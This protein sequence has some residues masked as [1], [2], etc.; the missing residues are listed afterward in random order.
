MYMLLRTGIG[1]CTCGKSAEGDTASIKRM[2]EEFDG[3]SREHLAINK[4]TYTCEMQ[5]AYTVKPP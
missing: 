2:S 4:G 1:L 3:L 5:F